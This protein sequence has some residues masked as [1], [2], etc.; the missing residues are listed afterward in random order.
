MA[1]RKTIGL[2]GGTFDPIHIGHLRVALELKQ[3]LG[4]D[5][6]RLLPCHIPPHRYTPVAEP[7]QRAAMVKLAVAD[8]SELIID[9]IEL[10]N[11]E[12][13]FS[14]HTLEILREQFG[15]EV[16][17]CLSMGMDSLMNLSTWHRWRE[18]LTLGHIIVAARP[19]SELPKTGEIAD[20][21]RQH[22]GDKVSLHAQAS[23]SIVIA[24]SSLLPISATAIREM[25]LQQESPQFLLPDSVLSYIEANGLYR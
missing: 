1:S 21:I 25:L 10:A 2:F 12:P 16:S 5:E 20:F 7:E 15:P 14:I 9:E 6:M 13:S 17:L 8:C 18:L 4:L 19:K 23:G 3:R 11:D 24:Q 22:E